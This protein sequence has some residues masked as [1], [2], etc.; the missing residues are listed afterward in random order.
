MIPNILPILHQAV[1]INR[2]SLRRFQQTRL[3]KLTID[4]T[5]LSTIPSQ[6]SQIHG[7]NTAVLIR[8][9]DPHSLLRTLNRASRNGV[10]QGSLQ[11]GI[12]LVIYSL[13]LKLKGKGKDRILPTTERS[14]GQQALCS[15]QAGISGAT[16]SHTALAVP[17]PGPRL[18]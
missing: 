6:T 14:R 13:G 16:I 11:A 2:P 3:L 7:T 1:N 4:I 10:L 12:D 18:N 15:R 8:R 5:I 9:A 17:T